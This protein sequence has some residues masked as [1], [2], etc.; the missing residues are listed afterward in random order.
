MFNF[1]SRIRMRLFL[2]CFAGN[3]QG[4]SPKKTIDKE[5]KKP[6]A[7]VKLPAKK[8]KTVRFDLPP[9]VMGEAEN[10]SEMPIYDDGF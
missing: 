5:D 8:K 2:C 4:D 6:A 9:T 1:S 7:D 10:N 3:K